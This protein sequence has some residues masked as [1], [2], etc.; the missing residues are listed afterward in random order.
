MDSD[1]DQKSGFSKREIGKGRGH[2]VN[3]QWEE[4]RMGLGVSLTAQAEE[5]N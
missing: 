5:E 1:P 2:K 3:A 4:E